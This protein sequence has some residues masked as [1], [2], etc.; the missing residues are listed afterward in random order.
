[1]GFDKE[2][3][4]DVVFIEGKP[5]NQTPAVYEEPRT[6]YHSI[7]VFPRPREEPAQQLLTPPATENADSDTEEPE[8]EIVD[9]QI[10]L[11]AS[12]TNE[13]T[14]QSTSGSSRSPIGGRS[15]L[16][17]MSARPN[18]GILTSA[19]FEDENLDKPG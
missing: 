19:N 8:P 5:I 6:I 1:M 10:L 9:P 4:R 14:S 11:E 15:K 2:R 17:R 16:T 18:K 12:M 3:S 7:T 13:P